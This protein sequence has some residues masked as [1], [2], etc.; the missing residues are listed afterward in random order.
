MKNYEEICN[1]IIAVAKRDGL[2]LI[3]AELENKGILVWFYKE[4]IVINSPYLERED[5]A[6]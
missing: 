2:R 5:V 3:K 4:F 1:S 6:V